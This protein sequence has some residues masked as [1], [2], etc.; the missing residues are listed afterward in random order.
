MRFRFMGALDRYILGA[1]FKIFFVTALGFPLLVIIID[2]TDNLSKY[3]ARDIPPAAL[4]RSYLYYIPESLFMVLPASVLFATVFT[5]GSLS[6]HSEVT[7][8]KASGISFYRLIAPLAMGATFAMLI[9]LV[10]GELVPISTARR[11]A[12]L[13]EKSQIGDNARY[14]FAYSAE[15]GRVYTI[16]ELTATPKGR[17]QAL[18]IVRR[19]TGPD[20]PTVITLANNGDWTGRAWHLQDG[21]VYINSTDTTVMALH[22]VA[23]RDRRMTETPRDLLQKATQPEE[24]QRAALGRYVRAMERSGA[25]VNPT[26][27]DLML[28]IAIP[29][30]CLIIFLF[31]APLAASNER[32]GA[33]FGIGLALATTVLFLM[34]VQLTKA[35]GNKGVLTPEL[36]AWIPS[37][38]FGVAGVILLSRART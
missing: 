17:L 28:R 18:E 29:V 34:L 27:V 1:F 7:A 36:A 20:Y 11:N 19:G 13:A 12:I 31:G 24:M 8:A 35:I 22:F 4:F 14:G 25:N 2:A 23:L 10:V 33:A 30:T 16:G 21:A 5:I 37:M 6:R 9:G 32:G 3:L 26:R 15:E 38:V